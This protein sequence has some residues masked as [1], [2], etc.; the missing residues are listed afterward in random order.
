M[1]IA[2]FPQSTREIHVVA[3]AG[4]SVRASALPLCQLLL[5][6]ALSSKSL[7]P[8]EG[9]LLCGAA[10][11]SPSAGWV[12]LGLAQWAGDSPGHCPRVTSAGGSVGLILLF[13]AAEVWRGSGL[14]S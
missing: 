11:S 8:G 6:Q 14:A 7:S 12:A 13:P 3:D 1:G 2:S 10:L 9:E 5:S 4:I